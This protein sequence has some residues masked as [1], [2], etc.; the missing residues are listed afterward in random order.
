MVSLLTA[1]RNFQANARAIDTATQI[2]Q[3]VLNLRQ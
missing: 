1:Q 2:S 3:T